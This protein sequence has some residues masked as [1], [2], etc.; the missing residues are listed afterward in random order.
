M[1]LDFAADH[2]ANQFAEMQLRAILRANGSSIAQ[3]G[4][5]I[6]QLRQRQGPHRVDVSLKALEAAIAL[7]RDV[8]DDE[9]VDHLGVGQCGQHGDLSPEG[10]PHQRPR[11]VAPRRN[12]GL[13]DRRR[14]ASLDA[15]ITLVEYVSAAAEQEVPV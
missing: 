9:P 7:G 10:V 6:G 13:G 5:P 14:R 15:L 1:I 8:D 4:D 2:P 11:V 12:E 3:H